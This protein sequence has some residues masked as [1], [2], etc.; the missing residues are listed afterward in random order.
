MILIFDKIQKWKNSRLILSFNARWFPP[1]NFLLLIKAA[2]LCSTRKGKGYS[3]P[4]EKLRWS[5]QK[6]YRVVNVVPT[7]CLSK[8]AGSRPEDSR[9]KQQPSHR[10]HRPNFSQHNSSGFQTAVKSQHTIFVAVLKGFWLTLNGS[11]ERCLISL[12]AVLKYSAAAPV[13]SCGRRRPLHDGYKLKQSD[14]D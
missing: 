7:A 13:A 3:N 8:N 11:L 6:T 4:R 1:V 12:W 9:H 10:Y 14:T 2:V 5:F